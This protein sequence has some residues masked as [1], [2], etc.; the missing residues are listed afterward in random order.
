MAKQPCARPGCRNLVVRGY[1]DDCASKHSSRAI[2]EQNRESAAKRGYGRRWQ[3]VRV[4]YL[5]AHPLCADPRRVHGVRVVAATELDHIV[6]H[7]GDMT[8]FW[9]PMNWQG[10][11]K[12]CHD[13]KT[14][15]EDGGFGRNRH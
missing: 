2:T 6:P 3:A 13:R 4:G 12:P 11:C 9:D 15:I 1:C 5:A 14:A 7:K 10:L 8:V